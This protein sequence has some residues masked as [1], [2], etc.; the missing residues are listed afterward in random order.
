MTSHYQVN[1]NKNYLYKTDNWPASPSTWL[2]TYTSI[3]TFTIV[4][5][6]KVFGVDDE[7]VK[8]LATVE[9]KLAA[10]MA[11]KYTKIGR[12]S[13]SSHIHVNGVGIL[14]F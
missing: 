8:V 2:C 12:A 14:H 5:L 10:T 13:I 4:A 9:G 6:T 7:L 3:I 11:V 1:S